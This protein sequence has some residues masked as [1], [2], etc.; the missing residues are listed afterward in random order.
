MTVHVRN[1]T[2]PGCGAPIT[3]EHERCSWCRRPIYLTSF[4][5][6][7]EMGQEELRRVSGWFQED[8]EKEGEVPVKNASAAMCWLRLGLYDQAV[9]AFERAIEEHFDQAETYFLAAVALMHGQ[10]PFQRT[11]SEVDRAA[12]WVQ[13]ALRIER[14]GIYYYLLAYLLYDFYGRK[15]LH[16]RISW[17]D[18]LREA[19]KAGVSRRD[20]RELHALMKTP[21]PEQLMF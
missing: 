19:L 21:W 1:L 14:Q 9:R 8:L 18:C 17:Q 16:P 20:V 2:C 5:S 11:R 4:S 6:V 12:A 13:A 3:M 15:H 7:Y 10:K